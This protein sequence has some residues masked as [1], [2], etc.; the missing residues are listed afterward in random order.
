MFGRDQFNQGSRFVQPQTTHES[1]LQGGLTLIQRALAVST[2]HPS[3]T[4][5]GAS[6]LRMLQLWSVL[7]RNRSGRAGRVEEALENCARG[8]PLNELVDHVDSP[9]LARPLL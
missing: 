8:G 2:R 3:K 5:V 4:I 9:V 7:M 6:G 1:N